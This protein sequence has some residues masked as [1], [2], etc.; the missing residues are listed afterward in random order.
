VRARIHQVIAEEAGKYTVFDLP[1]KKN[2]IMKVVRDDVIPFFKKKG[3][4]ITTLA[5]LGGITFDNADIQR[6]IDDAAKAAQLKVAA[7]M[8]RAAQEVENKTLLL[9][10]DGRAA[11]A[12]REA[13]SKA[14]VEL[15]RVEGDAKIKLSEAEAQAATLKKSADAKAYET[16][17]SAEAQADAIKLVAD[18]KAHE[19]QKASEQSET[20]VRLRMIEADIQRWKQWDGRYPQSIVQLGNGSGTTPIVMLPPLPMATPQK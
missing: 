2:D 14:E 3:I 19:A 1:A 16:Q 4:E 5:M 7:E 12:K 10:A 9:A 11:A 15:L 6:A 13:Q 20:Y 17:K 8:K 18:A